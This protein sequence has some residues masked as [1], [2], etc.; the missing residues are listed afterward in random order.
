MRDSK[1]SPKR[2]SLLIRAMSRTFKRESATDGEVI[3]ACIAVLLVNANECGIAREV[4]VD[5]IGALY[6][7]HT[8]RVSS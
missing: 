5:T 6:A 8:K 3:S 4:L 7:A 1:P 2:V